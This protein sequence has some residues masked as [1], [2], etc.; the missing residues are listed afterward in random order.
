MTQWAV[1]P[2]HHGA[3]QVYPL[4]DLKE[5]LLERPCWC[6]PSY[7]E[8]DDILIH[9]AADEREKFETGERKPS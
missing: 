4:R 8:E 9:N 7:D 2:G 5:H 6:N 1:D 3:N